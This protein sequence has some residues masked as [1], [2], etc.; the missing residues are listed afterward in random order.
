MDFKNVHVLV[1]DGGG[2]QTLTIIRGLKEIG[3]HVTV[4]CRSKMD[5]CYVSKYPDVKLL[6]KDIIGDDSFYK[7]LLRELKTEKYDVLFPIAENSTN[8]V[9][10]HEEECK[11]YVRIACAPRDIYIRAFNK[12]I[13]FETAMTAGIPC[14]ITRRDNETIEDFLSRTPFP[15]IIK[16]RNSVGSIGFHKF[17]S[18]VE[19]ERFVVDQK[20][21][22][23][24]YVVQEFIHF[25]KRRSAFIVMD[26]KGNVKGALAGEIKRWYPVDAGTC[27][28][29]QTVDDNVVLDY[30]IKLL[31]EM[32]WKGFANVCFM[33]DDND[34]IVKLLEINGRINASI[35][36]CFMCGYNIS[37]QML[38]LAF[39]EPVTSYPINDKF[40]V[41]TRHFQA[42]FMWFLK[43][44]NRFN[45][46]PSWFSW[47][48]AKDIVF[49]RD[50]PL[51]FFAY[52]FAQMTRYKKAM[53]KRE[54]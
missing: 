49:Y 32:R 48:N 26:E 1:T 12:Q 17:D 27:T 2:R 21:N 47:K 29:L 3:C 44:P 4:L 6:E 31:Q 18:R 54:R 45:S 46:D 53:K 51:P 10:L 42:D 11:K 25:T 8:L 16:P 30:A 41:T 13:T 24:D 37:K 14:P 38:E 40:G 39:G 23:D 33:T 7:V 22:L 34:G 35:K 20:T 52:S 9:T 19:F 5:L 50:D 36:L 15:I 43:S 28:C